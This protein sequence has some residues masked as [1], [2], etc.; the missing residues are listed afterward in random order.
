MRFFAD[1]IIDIVLGSS[2][3]GCELTESCY[4]AL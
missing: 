3:P 1:K 2:V 4:P